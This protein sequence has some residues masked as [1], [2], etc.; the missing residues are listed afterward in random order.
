MH[1]RHLFLA[2]LL[3]LGVGARAE[4]DFIYTVQPGDHPWNIAQRYLRDTSDALRIT[5]LNRIIHDRTIAPGTRLHIPAQWLRL[6]SAQVDL[7]KVH[8]DALVIT[9]QGSQAA[10]VGE[11]LLPGARLRTGPRSSVMLAFEDGSQV[12]MRQASELRLV[13]SERRAIDGGFLVQVELVRGA[14]EN[15]VTPRARPDTRFEIRT[16]AAVAAVRG[17]R[18]R[19]D[20]S[21]LVTRT[22]V[23][24]GAVEVSNPGGTVRASAGFGALTELG[25]GPQSPRPLL[26]GPDLTGVPP[27]I[28]RL[29]LDL[30]LPALAQ[31]AGYRTQLAPDAAFAT[32]VSDEV[33][34]APRARVLDVADGHYVMRVR[35]AAADG[36]EGL[37]T[38]RAITVHAR[39][40]A[41]SLISP[42]PDAQTSEARPV[43]RWTE[44]DPSWRYRIEL[45]RGPDTATLPDHVQLA[46]RSSGTVLDVDLEPGRWF[47][48]V[49]SVVPATG[50]QGPW[51]DPQPFRRVLASPQAAPAEVAPGAV[52]I[53]WPALPYAAGY[54][55]ELAGAAGFELPLRSLRTTSAQQSWSDLLPG[56][57]LIRLRAVSRDGVPGPWGEP[58]RFVV[59]APPAA[60]PTGWSPWLLLPGLLLLGL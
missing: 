41:P 12:L 13:Q 36:L 60:P 3:A 2:C 56:D 14:L 39:P 9:D 51:G 47:W 42:A 37:A 33:S 27:R 1:F 21:E 20:A 24:E 34:V 6:E 23:L 53:R 5:R 17:T 58:Q 50:R 30:P 43:F 35:A 18:F 52:T 57:Y 38:E 4:E 10:Q 26:A 48:R 55:L 31:A 7:L 32:I 11:R 46:E 44:I 59:P 25:Q 29:P 19:V 40:Q 15:M 28:E 16:P 45:R 22:E 49:A 54:D 8:G